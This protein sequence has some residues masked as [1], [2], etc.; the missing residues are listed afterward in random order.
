MPNVSCLLCLAQAGSMDL[1]PATRY[2]TSIRGNTLGSYSSALPRPLFWGPTGPLITFPL[3]SRPNV[4]FIG[5]LGL[6]GPYAMSPIIRLLI[7]S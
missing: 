3:W 4:V 5:F 6:M 7:I 1:A 2:K